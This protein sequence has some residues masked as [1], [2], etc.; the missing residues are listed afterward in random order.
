MGRLII[1]GPVAG[2]AT[3]S[4]RLPVCVRSLLAHAHSALKLFECVLIRTS[5]AEAAQ[6]F[7]SGKSGR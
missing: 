5:P 1:A 6:P 4:P 7:R 3:P 2:V